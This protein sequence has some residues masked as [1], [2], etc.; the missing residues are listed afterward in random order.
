[1]SKH[2]KKSTVKNLTDIMKTAENWRKEIVKTENGTKK[3]G[4]TKFVKTIME[5]VQP[6]SL[7]TDYFRDW[8]AVKEERN[9]KLALDEEGKR[10][11]GFDIYRDSWFDYPII[12]QSKLGG[13]WN[14]YNRFIS[15]HSSACTFSCWHCY[16]EEELKNPVIAAKEGFMEFVSAD[17]VVENF[18]K[19]KEVDEG[20]DMED[21][22][23]RITGGEPFLMPDFIL[24]VLKKI[25]NIGKNKE[26][27]VWTET[28]LIPFF[29][30]KG[31][32]H[33]W[34]EKWVN[35]NEIASF[36]NFCIH[37]CLHGISPENFQWITQ[38]HPKYFD[39]LL[40]GLNT[41]IEYKLEIYPTFGSNVSPPK[42]L[43]YIFE[44][45]IKINDNLPLRFALI[46]YEVDCYL[47]VVRRII[48]SSKP[49]QMYN[50]ILVIDRWSKLLKERYGI[51]YAEKPRHEVP[52]W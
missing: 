14:Q 32:N 39:E 6:G 46:D 16:V 51:G 2:S 45:L 41:L 50:K 36:K 1:M 44:K 23:L 19:Q 10:C 15:V 5:G 42:M 9:R 34:V 35:I 3:Y 31:E 52:L 26:I 12:I 11:N 37:P 40:N 24:E 8:V 21:N 7:V 38:S 18:L 43:P 25:E 13:H 49:E 22:V 48:T 30:K 29:K 47:P 17:E 20:K 28:N 4:V 33:I 27:F